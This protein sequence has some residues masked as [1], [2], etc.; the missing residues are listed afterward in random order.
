MIRTVDLQV[1]LSGLLPDTV[2]TRHGTKIAGDWR[3]GTLREAFYCGAQQQ[4]SRH[5]LSRQHEV[6]PLGDAYERWRVVLSG[7][8]RKLRRSPGL[9]TA[10]AEAAAVLVG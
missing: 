10:I 3:E 2:Q 5:E 9:Y 7:R 1:R 8:H 4:V 6:A